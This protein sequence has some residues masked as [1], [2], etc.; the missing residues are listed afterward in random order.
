MGAAALMIAGVF[1][2]LLIYPQ[3]VEREADRSHSAAMI[4]QRLAP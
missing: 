1:S 3:W 4:T 2:A